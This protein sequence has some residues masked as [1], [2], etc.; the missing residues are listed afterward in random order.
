M[1]VKEEDELGDTV[2]HDGRSVL[3]RNEFECSEK[4]KR[5]RV[6]VVGL[7]Y[8]ELYLNGEKVGNHVLSPAKTNYRKEILYD[9][10]DITNELKKGNNAVGIHLGNGWFNPYKKWWKEYR[11]Q[12]FGAKR[13]F[14]QMH[15]EYENGDKKVIVTDENWKFQHGPVLY[16]CIYDGEFYDATKEIPGWADENFDDSG[17]EMV[18]T[19]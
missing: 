9:T 17:W 14:L 5:A 4:V 13:A 15:I 8:Y 11:M 18:N 7:G 12:W 19:G 6:F 16:N 3:L 1:D 2:K 10:Y